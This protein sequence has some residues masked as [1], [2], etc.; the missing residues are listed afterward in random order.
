[1]KK[2][3]ILTIIVVVGFIGISC[4]GN[5]EKQSSC[6]CNPKEHNE[7]ENCCNGNGCNCTII[8]KCDC[9]DGTFHL[10]S[11]NCRGPLNCECELNVKGVRSNVPDKATNGIPITN[12]FNIIEGVPNNYSASFDEMVNRVN[13]SLNHNVLSTNNYQNF[14]KDNLKE[15]RIIESTGGEISLIFASEGVIVFENNWSALNIRSRFREWCVNSGIYMFSVRYMPN[16]ANVGHPDDYQAF[17]AGM[18]FYLSGD[19]GMINNGKMFI[20]WNTEADGSGVNYEVGQKIII[21]NILEDNVILA[22]W[23][24]WE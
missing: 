14:I 3:W 18:E 4:G 8:L 11:E 10:I 22:L 16:G 7:G 20:G 15:I 5:D 2:L 12:R 17:E 21:D 24:Q 23:A 9:P 13:T 1:M 19:G 6:E